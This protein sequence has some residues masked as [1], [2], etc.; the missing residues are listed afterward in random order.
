[1][2]PPPNSDLGYTARIQIVPSEVVLAMA[3]G[4]IATVLG[5][6]L[7]ARRVLRTPIVDALRQNA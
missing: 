1:M 6:M 7:P 5:A 3:V 4:A 2:P